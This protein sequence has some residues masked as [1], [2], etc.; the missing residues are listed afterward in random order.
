LNPTLI[1]SMRDD[2]VFITDLDLVFLLM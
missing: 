1:G 2:G